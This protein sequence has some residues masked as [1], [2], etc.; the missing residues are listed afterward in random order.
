M[1]NEKIQKYFENKLKKYDFLFWKISFHYLN[2]RIKMFYV[3]SLQL[4]QV[5]MEEAGFPN[6]YISF[7]AAHLEQKK[8]IA[9]SQPSVLNSYRKMSLVWNMWLGSLLVLEEKVMKLL[10]HEKIIKKE[11]LKISVNFE[12]LPKGFL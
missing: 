1:T 6:W 8:Y 2:E 10:L 3:V 9:H 11:D 4:D 5:K 7:V 12:R